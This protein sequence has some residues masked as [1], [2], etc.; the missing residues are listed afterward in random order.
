M[1]RSSDESGTDDDNDDEKKQK[2]I[3]E[4]ARNVNLKT[5]LAR[6]FGLVPGMYYVQ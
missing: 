3:P 2:T 1:N 5:A 4:W 6:Q